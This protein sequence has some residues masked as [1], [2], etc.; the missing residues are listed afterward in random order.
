[1]ISLDI[2]T[3]VSEG[4]DTNQHHKMFSVILEMDNPINLFWFET[5]LQPKITFICYLD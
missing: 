4:F 1:V 3:V 2:F 5:L